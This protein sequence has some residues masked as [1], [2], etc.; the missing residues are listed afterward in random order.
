MRSLRLKMIRRDVIYK[1]RVQRVGFRWTVN[2]LARNYGVSGF[3]ENRSD[4][5]V[6]MVVEGSKTEVDE[7]MNSI[8]ARMTTNIV[9]TVV[10]DAVATGA[11]TTFSVHY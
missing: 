10:K 9:D 3:V 5:T 2:H 11:N 8:S 7:F 6:Y 4:G 1:G